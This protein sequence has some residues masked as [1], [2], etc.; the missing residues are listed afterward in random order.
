[1]LRRLVD[2]GV[3]CSYV[4]LSAASFV[5]RQVSRNS[6]RFTFAN[7]LCYI[8]TKSFYHQSLG[9]KNIARCSCSFG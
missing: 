2:M 5:M 3:Q 9:F 1:M 6:F 8:N 4:H 7:L